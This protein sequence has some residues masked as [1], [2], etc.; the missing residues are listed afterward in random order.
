MGCRPDFPFACEGTFLSEPRF[1]LQREYE[2]PLACR[3]STPTL[4]GVVLALGIAI[5]IQKGHTSVLFFV[6]QLCFAF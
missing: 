1:P 2:D 3:W 4:D 5:L 6:G